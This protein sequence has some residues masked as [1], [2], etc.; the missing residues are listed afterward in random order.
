MM[1]M[2]MSIVEYLIKDD[3]SWPTLGDLEFIVIGNLDT[4][5]LE[6]SFK[7]EV[8]EVVFDLGADIALGPDCFPMIY[9][10]SEIL[11]RC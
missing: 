4:D 7:E 10:F 11:E 5:R 9:F 1:M 2:M 3:Y 8:K 6:R